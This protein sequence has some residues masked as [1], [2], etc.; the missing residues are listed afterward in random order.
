[1]GGNYCIS[2]RVECHGAALRPKRGKLYVPTALLRTIKGIK[3]KE[4]ARLARSA[5]NAKDK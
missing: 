3:A 4:I 5:Q 2:L 1:M